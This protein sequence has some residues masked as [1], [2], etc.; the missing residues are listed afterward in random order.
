MQVFGVFHMKDTF[1]LRT[2]WWDAISELN[3]EEQ[4]EI[5]R[6]LFLYHLEEPNFNLNNLINLS[7][8]LVWKMIEPN[9]K[10]NIDA[11]DKRCEQSKKN[12]KL[13]GR[14]KTKKNLKKPLSDTD[15]DSDTDSDSVSENESVSEKEKENEKYADAPASNDP[16]LAS[17]PDKKFLSSKKKAVEAQ[18]KPDKQPQQNNQTIST[19][20][21]LI[22]CR[23][24]YEQWCEKK[25][26]APAII[27]G[28]EIKSL[29]TICKYLRKLV[30]LK[31][32]KDSNAPA[33]I[34]VSNEEI[35]AALKY[36]LDNFDKWDAFHQKNIQLSQIASNIQNI[37]N[38]IINPRQNGK[39]TYHKNGYLTDEE[40]A[41]IGKGTEK[42]LEGII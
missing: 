40:A 39:Q 32:K 34:I 42:F 12:G 13:G 17:A 28:K 24:I 15:T 37:T 8:K 23:D 26:N 4:A 3:S 30:T 19:Q 25:L 31:K 20:K 14:P 7:V 10:R 1:I 27:N 18:P 33:E 38:S 36:T 21:F 41:I 6:L 35:T 16:T 22:P 5:I 9:L 2:E 29:E 11:Y